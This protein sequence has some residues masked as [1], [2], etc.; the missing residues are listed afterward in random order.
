[1]ESLFTDIVVFHYHYVFLLAGLLLLYCAFV[2]AKRLVDWG[3]AKG[4]GYFLS[5]LLGSLIFLNL[6]FFILVIGNEEAQAI[7]FLPYLLQLIGLYGFLMM[8]TLG[9]KTIINRLIS[10]KA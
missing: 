3:L 7:T 8:V 5:Y 4:R 1:M 2:L 9:V 6:F 10:K